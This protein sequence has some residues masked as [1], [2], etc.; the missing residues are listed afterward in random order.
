MGTCGA[1]KESK[2]NNLACT[3]EIVCPFSESLA[4]TSPKR[5]W[6]RKRH[7]ENFFQPKSYEDGKI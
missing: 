7:D 4:P 2:N 1:Y 6:R 3:Q 5:M